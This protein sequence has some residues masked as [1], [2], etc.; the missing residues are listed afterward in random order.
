MN[1]GDDV[2]TTDGDDDEGLELLQRARLLVQAATNLPDFSTLFSKT[3]TP[4]ITEEEATPE[5]TKSKGKKPKASNQNEPRKQ[6]EKKVIKPSPEASTMCAASHFSKSPRSRRPK[7]S[8][9]PKRSPEP[10]KFKRSPKPAKPKPKKEV[11]EEPPVEDDAEKK[12]AQALARKYAQDRAAARV[13]AKQREKLREAEKQQQTETECVQ[14]FY[15]T[16]EEREARLREDRRKAKERARLRRQTTEAKDPEEKEPAKAAHP[17]VDLEKFQQQTKERLMR[18]KELR[19][20]E[21][22]LKQQALAKEQEEKARHEQ[23]DEEAREEMRQRAE[24]L[25]KQT[26]R[27]L[28]AMEKHKTELEQKEQELRQQGLERYKHHKDEMERVAKGIGAKPKEAAP[29]IDKLPALSPAAVKDA[30]DDADDEVA[31]PAEDLS[32]EAPSPEKLVAPVEVVVEEPEREHDEEELVSSSVLPPLVEDTKVDRPVKVKKALWKRPPVPMPSVDAIAGRVKLPAPVPPP[33][34]SSYADRMKSR[35]AP[36]S[37]GSCD[38]Q[39]QRLASAT[40]ERAK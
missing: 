25:R 18:A 5:P 23:E 13:A 32:V 28:K 24:Q 38:T 15:E 14:E 11:P 29:P 20:R 16:L 10:A 21:E 3:P 2:H 30:T 40:R 12:A 34:D 9:K 1:Q 6:D 7:A 35:S 33:R 17:Q 36:S 4:P 37:L 27:R 22:A 19:R 26:R 8:P 39:A 31:G